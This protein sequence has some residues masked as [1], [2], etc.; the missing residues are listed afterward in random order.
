MIARVPSLH[1]SAV[2]FLAL[3]AF[4]AACDD[5]GSPSGPGKDGGPNGSDG[6][7]NGVHSWYGDIG[8]MLIEHCGG[9]HQDGGIAPFEINYESAYQWRALI[10]S[11]T[12]ARTMPPMPVNNDGSCRTYSNARWLSDDQIEDIGEWVDAGAPEGVEK[13][14]PGLPA[15]AEL[16]DPDVETDTGIDYMA[17][18]DVSDDYR[19]FPIAW[20]QASDKYMTAYEVV[21]GNRQIAHHMIL[22][23]IADDQKSWVTQEDAKDETPGYPCYGSASPGNPMPVVLWAPGSGRTDMP[24]GT[25]IKIPQNAMLVM[26]M[27]YNLANGPGTDRT[28]IR[29]KLADSVTEPAIYVPLLNSQIDIQPQ[30]EEEVELPGSTYEAGHLPIPNVEIPIP[31]TIHGVFPHMH[32]KGTKLKVT[33]ESTETGE[34]CLVDV[35]KWDFNWQEGW[36]YDEPFVMPSTGTNRAFDITCTF[37]STGTNTVTNWGEGSS[38]EMCLTF[39]YATSPLLEYLGF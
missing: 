31:L 6:S 18:G 19:C 2:P 7:D 26:Q 10:K 20:N 28:T 37:N 3:L 27:H 11:T 9:C 35:H 4:V 24:A 14:L 21:P 12:E 16:K 39:A 30:M 13:E 1:R 17:N 8:P 36:W 25:G 5:S 38:D 32:Q 34:E 23:M 22:Y 15:G 29:M 33:F